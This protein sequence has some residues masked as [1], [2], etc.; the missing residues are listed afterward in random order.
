MSGFFSGVF[1]MSFVRTFSRG[2]ALAALTFV[3]VQGA[4]AQN[5]SKAKAT[6]ASGSS[7]GI[8]SV[9]ADG[10]GS[11]NQSAT[12]AI[13]TNTT[14]P[15]TTS[16][17]GLAE[18]ISAAEPRRFFGEFYTETN[19]D[20]TDIEKGAGTPNFDT[21]FGVKYDFGNARAFS[22]RQNFNYASASG[23]GFGDFHIQDLALNYVDGK[24]GKFM[25]DGSIIM[26]ARAY[27]PTGEKS[28]FITH[29]AGK[30]RLY[31]F[32]AK[33][34]GKWDLTLVQLGQLFNST[35]TYYL[36]GKGRAQLTPISQVTAEFDAFYN[37]NSVLSFGAIAGIDHGWFNSYSNK[38]TQAADFYIQP[39]IQVIP[40]KGL[41]AQVYLY[42]QVDIRNPVH[43]FAL[44]RDD[45]GDNDALQIWA[46]LAASL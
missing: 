46:N 12:T 22:V 25:N 42:N 31:L 30:E 29:Q 45:G 35:Q 5:V 3:A 21:Y 19:E 15:V 39:T 38:D 9:A 23:G 33:S 2:L 13:I 14:D 36:D 1:S 37:V 40:T 41:T 43:D 6:Q 28:R 10:A 7:D 24:L 32:E 27:L 17:A 4:H 26:I 18:A 8:E 44:L 20:M 34:F 11:P 16:T